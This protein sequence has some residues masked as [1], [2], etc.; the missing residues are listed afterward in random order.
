MS[1]LPSRPRAY[2]TDYGMTWYPSD[3]ESIITV[4]RFNTV[5]GRAVLQIVARDRTQRID[6]AAILQ[7][8]VSKKGRVIRTYPI[9]GN[10]GEHWG[11]PED[12]AAIG[13]G[14]E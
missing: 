14:D 8:T 10:V 12:N 5:N 11:N 13:D 2:S 9:Q 1:E 4:E 7:V 6:D 3:A